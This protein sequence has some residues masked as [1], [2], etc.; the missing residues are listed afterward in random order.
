MKLFVDQSMPSRTALFRFTVLITIFAA[1]T[2]V[3]NYFAVVMNATL[4]SE[5]ETS[6][7]HF[8]RLRKTQFQGAKHAALSKGFFLLVILQMILKLLWPCFLFV[9]MLYPQWSKQAAPK[10]GDSELVTMAAPVLFVLYMVSNAI[11]VMQ[12][13]SEKRLE[14]I[15]DY[16]RKVRDEKMQAESDRSSLTQGTSIPKKKAHLSKKAN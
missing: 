5:A 15:E 12:T 4:I 14:V 8:L 13:I 1:A 10:E 6:L 9:S 3:K 7:N 16:K 2:Q 11:L